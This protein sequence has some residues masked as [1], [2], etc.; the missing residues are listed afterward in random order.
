MLLQVINHSVTKGRIVRPITKAHVLASR[1]KQ[2][3][4]DDLLGVERHLPKL[5]RT[6]LFGNRMAFHS[7]RNWAD[8][9]CGGFPVSSRESIVYWI[10]PAPVRQAVLSIYFMCNDPRLSYR[11]IALHKLY[12]QCCTRVVRKRVW[13]P[14]I[15][16][17]S[18]RYLFP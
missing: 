5:H 6:E 8:W 3:S 15:S 12:S 7:V 10:S 2:P 11:S 1:Y 13:K 17:L 4:F 9:I 14:T 18:Y 16:M